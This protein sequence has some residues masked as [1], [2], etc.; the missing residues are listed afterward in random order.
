MPMDAMSDNINVSLNRCFMRFDDRAERLNAQQIVDTFVAVGPMLDVLA[1]RSH[2][3][4]YGRRG[5][6]KTHALRYFESQANKR[7]DLAIYIDCGNIGSN[8]STY[9]DATLSTT[10]RA[11]RLT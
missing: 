9:N 3:V 5:V 8:N 6:G 11:T 4:I 2:Q 7:G 10:E 1:N